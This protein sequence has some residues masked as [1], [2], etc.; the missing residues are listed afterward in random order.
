MLV[1]AMNDAPAQ[2]AS[3]LALPRLCGRIVD[4]RGVLIRVAG[5]SL[6][7]G[8]RVRIRS[9]REGVEQQG[10]V[11]GLEGPLALVLPLNGLRGLSSICEVESGGRHGLD[12]DA[13]LAR[14][15]VIDGLGEP[16]DGGPTLP[17]THAPVVAS[18]APLERPPIDRPLVSGWRAMDGLLTCG[19]GQRIGIFA[20]AGAGKSTLLGSFAQAIAC[21]TVVLALIG[22]RS[23]EVAD[24]LHQHL[25]QRRGATIAVV[26]TSDRSPAERL[27]AAE[28]AARLACRLREQ[29]QHVLLLVDSLTRYARAGRE[30]GLALGEPAGSGGFP[31]SVQARLAQ[32]VEAGGR[33]ASGSVTGFYT[34]LCDHDDA[35]L[36]E[37]V[38]SLMDGH[39]QLSSALAEAGHF[40]AIDL[41]RSQSR[42]SDRLVPS[43]QRLHAARFRQW[44]ARYAELEWLIQVGEY[45][46]G[47][48]AEADLAIAH[49][50]KLLQFLQ[51]PR[52]DA[53]LQQTRDALARI[54]DPEP[55]R[56]GLHG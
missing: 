25:G 22:E 51:Q 28:L 17:R 34:L 7:I 5:L 16:L 13:V 6:H 45:R 42:L 40:P 20:P 54:F 9:G 12:V 49:R 33:S 2:G 43:E 44:L 31:P 10:E 18:V 48:D 1:G 55:T 47:A 41:L 39:I 14:G 27:C 56:T 19:E 8:E 46:P 4:A 29:G 26:A 30:L 37:E 32:L 38:R 24:F 15:R 21:D 53:S 3:A 11:V 35:P 36:A 23:R 50:P 52:N